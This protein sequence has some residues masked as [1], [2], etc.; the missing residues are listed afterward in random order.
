MILVVFDEWDESCGATNAE[1]AI[2]AY[3]LIEVCSDDGKVGGRRPLKS[4]KC[5]SH[6]EIK[7]LSG[8][9]KPDG[10]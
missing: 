7:N 5:A 3:N 8:K 6:V 1:T 9:D 10:S 4:G 2:A